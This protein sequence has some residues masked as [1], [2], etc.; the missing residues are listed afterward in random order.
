MQPN[1]NA[2]AVQHF[3]NIAN[4]ESF[5]I[6]LNIA[7]AESFLIALFRMRTRKFVFHYLFAGDQNK[8]AS[9]LSFNYICAQFLLLLVLRQRSRRVLL[10]NKYKKIQTD[11]QTDRQTNKQTDWL[12]NSE[13]NV[14]HVLR[15]QCW[16]TNRDIKRWFT[17]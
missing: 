7:N 17:I 2:H 12:T 8:M 4:V 3:A 15:S 16:D 9:I 10:W 6:A 5:L 13:I 14:V 11:R 1:K